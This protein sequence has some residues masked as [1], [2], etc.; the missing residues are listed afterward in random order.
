MWY[1]FSRQGVIIYM[2]HLYRYSLVLALILILFCGRAEAKK[3]KWVKYYGPDLVNIPQET[4]ISIES[5]TGRAWK[6]YTLEEK[7]ALLDKNEAEKK[8]R[9]LKKKKLLKEEQRFEKE[10]KAAKKEELEKIKA[11]QERE[12]ERKKAIEKAKQEEEKKFRKAIRL[13]EKKMLELKKKQLIRS[14]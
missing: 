2:Q 1:T 6:S 8:S 4:R 10:K 7:A 9:E 14:R 12:R 13:K 11:M 3:I 5:A